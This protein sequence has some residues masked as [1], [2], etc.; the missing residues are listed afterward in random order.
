M[1]RTGLTA[2]SR[3]A[4]YFWESQRFSS[5]HQLKPIKDQ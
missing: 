5:L 4:R 1:A 2:E 3:P